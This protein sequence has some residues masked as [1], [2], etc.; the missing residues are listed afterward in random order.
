M[1]HPIGSPGSVHRHSFFAAP[2]K[3]QS[4]FVPNPSN[5]CQRSNHWQSV[6]SL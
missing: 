3:I 2:S 5:R 4:L 1:R 6:D